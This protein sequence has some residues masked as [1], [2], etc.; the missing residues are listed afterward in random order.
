MEMHGLVDAKRSGIANN[1]SQSCTAVMVCKSCASLSMHPRQRVAAH[2]HNFMTSAVHVLNG[3]K[4]I[5]VTVATF[6]CLPICAPVAL[7]RA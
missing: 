2:S 3:F 4:N 1:T 5:A 7:T 6:S